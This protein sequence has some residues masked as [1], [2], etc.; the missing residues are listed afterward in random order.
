[1]FFSFA[2]ILPVDLEV[3][4]ILKEQISKLYILAAT[5]RAKTTGPFSG[6]DK[7]IKNT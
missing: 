5:L 6:G 2:K 1:M 4:I 7:S 3:G